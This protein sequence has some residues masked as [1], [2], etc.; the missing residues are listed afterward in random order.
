[1]NIGSISTPSSQ[2]SAR[3]DL[4]EI[5]LPHRHMSR[6]SRSPFRQFECKAVFPKSAGGLKVQLVQPTLADL[7]TLREKLPHAVLSKIHI[8]VARQG[9]FRK[10]NSGWCIRESLH[11]TNPTGWISSCVPLDKAELLRVVYDELDQVTGGF[12]EIG[13][14]SLHSKWIYC[15]SDLFDLRLASV[16]ADGFKPLW[17]VVADDEDGATAFTADKGLQALKSLVVGFVLPHR[18]ADRLQ[19]SIGWDDLIPCVAG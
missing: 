11:G 6:V 8:A 10:L 4:I 9:N 3:I 18:Q 7:Q 17:S 19:S 15:L 12:L 2:F 1:M 5:E 13:A 16:F 14:F